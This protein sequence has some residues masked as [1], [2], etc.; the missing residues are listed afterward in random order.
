MSDETSITI[1][2]NGFREQHIVAA[3]AGSLVER[4]SDEIDR[5]VRERIDGALTSLLDGEIKEQITARVKVA[6]EEGFDETNHYGEWTGKRISLRE[7][8]A[9]LLT[10]KHREGYQG[11]EETI[12]ERLARKTIEESLAGAFNDEIAEARKRLRAALDNALAQKVAEALRQ[13]LRL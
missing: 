12:V 1:T 10:E 5:I 9:K 7:R 11:P 3:V 2:L 6:V 4:H 8:I 13:E